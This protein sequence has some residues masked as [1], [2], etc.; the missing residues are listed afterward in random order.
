MHNKPVDVV[1]SPSK[2]EPE[3]LARNALQS[4]PDAEI[5]HEIIG[6]AQADTCTQSKKVRFLVVFGW[7]LERL[8]FG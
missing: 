4:L 2:Q 6:H 3:H 5:R 1:E 8:A 7:L